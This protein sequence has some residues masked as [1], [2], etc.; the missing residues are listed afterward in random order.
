MNI[1]KNDTA[2]VLID[3][4]NEVLSEKGLGWGLLGESVRENH[5]VENLARLFRAAKVS[6]MTP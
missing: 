2:V 3:P 4:Q 5:T 1:D 6:G